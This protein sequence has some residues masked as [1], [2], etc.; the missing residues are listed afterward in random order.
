MP[1]NKLG[2][3]LGKL[4]FTVTY[5]HHYKGISQL[6]LLMGLFIVY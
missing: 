4:D 5:S 2:E 3:T 1:L 6:Q